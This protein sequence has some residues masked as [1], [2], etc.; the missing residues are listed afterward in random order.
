VENEDSA[1]G[2]KPVPEILHTCFYVGINRNLTDIKTE[3]TV[4][5]APAVETPL[6]HVVLF[7][8]GTTTYIK[9]I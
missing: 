7:H 3:T 9:S 8:I 4:A 2:L 1:L 6:T 5:T